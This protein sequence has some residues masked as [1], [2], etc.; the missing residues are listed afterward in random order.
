MLKDRKDGVVY[1]HWCALT[2]AAAGAYIGWLAFAEAS[3][4]FHGVRGPNVWLYLFGVV[5]ASFWQHRGLHLSGHRLGDMGFIESMRHSWHQLFRFVIVLFT[6][7]FVIKDNEVSRKFLFGYI[8]LMAFVLTA[9]NVYFPRIIVRLFF[10]KVLMRTLL[11]AKPDEVMKL[12]CMMA[13][14]EHLGIKIVGWVGDSE[15]GASS[16]IP[17]PKLGVLDDLRRVLQE[18][19]VAQVVVSQHSF[20]L[21]EGRAIAQC[22]EEAACRVRFFAHVQKYFPAQ[23]I[24]VEHEG[25]FTF[26][27]QASEP[28][29][30]PM[31]RLL[32]RVLDIA[33]SLPVV[34]FVL[35]PLT[36]LVWIMQ[37]RQ[38]SG[39][40]IHRQY[41]SGLN[42]TKFLIFKYRTMHVA[43][44]AAALT[45]QAQAND[46][47]VFPFGRFLR[48]TSLDE[49]PQFLNVL[50]GD[51][52]VSGPRPHLLEHD[53][54]F[55]K[56][57]NSYYT[58]HFVK[59]G[60]TGLAQT[61]GFR[62]EISEP[63]MLQKRIGYDMIY[64]R[65]WTLSLDL[66][67]LFQTASQVVFPP[68]SAY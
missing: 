46:S 65:R 34:L 6:L 30:N 12:H 10:R 36:L 44:T 25:Q 67:I 33:V 57:V 54:Q 50:M 48:R 13:A 37:W 56:I 15:P 63:S 29:E 16:Q 55:S 35:P 47:R 41:R 45:K 32:K 51:M 60:I 27:T 14:R 3:P 9:A 17:L 58:R 61:R 19:N 62:G 59:P 2:V 38:S 20:P 11:V 24:S 31:N 1:L 66:R 8:F 68:R 52:S 22:A 40:V 26:V 64:I 18:H 53:E 28:L 5:I 21:E 4:A 42:R 7:A 43:D 39:P 23:S 49:F